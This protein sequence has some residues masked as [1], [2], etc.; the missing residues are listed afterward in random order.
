MVMYRGIFPGGRP[1]TRAKKVYTE[2]IV[3]KTAVESRPLLM[4]Q[5]CAQHAALS[6]TSPSLNQTRLK[7]KANDWLMSP[8][9]RL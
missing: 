5:P 6:F 4:N 3:K 9:R 1:R 7:Q 2:I 8:S